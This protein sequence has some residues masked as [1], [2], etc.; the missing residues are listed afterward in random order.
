MR[1]GVVAKR[2]DRTWAPIRGR[3]PGHHA[4]AP[5][6]QRRVSSLVAELGRHPPRV[7][8]GR[9]EAHEWV[10][11]HHRS[12]TIGVRRG[13]RDRHGRPVP[14]GHDRRTFRADRVKHSHEVAHRFFKP[15]AEVAARVHRA[16]WVRQPCAAPV[17]E[18]H[19]GERRQ[20]TVEP[21]GHGEIP[22]SFDRLRP[23]RDV[24]EI[25]RALTESLVRNQPIGAVRVLHLGDRE[26][27]TTLTTRHS[28]D[29]WWP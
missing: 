17:D 8:L 21:L 9:Q 6:E 4:L 29:V 19:T 27:D 16:K 24:N 23:T 15:R 5:G 25:N 20:A 7:V 2:R 22:D 14:V 12:D 13:E 1:F 18:H 26:H 28:H 10:N 3:H 11:E